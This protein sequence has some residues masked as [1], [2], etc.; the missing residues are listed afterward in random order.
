[1]KLSTKYALN[2]SFYFHDISMELL[3][4]YALNSSFYFH[5]ISIEQFTSTCFIVFSVTRCEHCTNITHCKQLYMS[6]YV[7]C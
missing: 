4:K 3:T 1:M 5:D 6:R 7:T 2:S